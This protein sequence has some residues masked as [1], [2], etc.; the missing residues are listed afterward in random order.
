[1]PLPAHCARD[2]CTKLAKGD[3]FCSQ[4]C[5]KI[6]NGLVEFDPDME[7]KL[8]NQRRRQARLARKHGA[9]FV[10]VDNPDAFGHVIAGGYGT[11]KKQ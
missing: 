5:F 4:L 6:H 1:M 3:E 10:D 7:R 9:P 11:G 8:R 2:G